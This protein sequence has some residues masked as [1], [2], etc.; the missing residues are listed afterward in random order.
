MDATH[1]GLSVCGSVRQNGPLYFKQ[2]GKCSIAPPLYSQLKGQRSGSKSQ[3][4]RK[5]RDYF[6]VVTLLQI[7]YLLVHS[8]QIPAAGMLAVC[9]ALQIFCCFFYRAMLCISAV[10]AVMRCLSVRLSVRLSVTFVDHVKTNK[11]IF[12]IFS[13]AGS[14]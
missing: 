13:P 5:C 9:L 14:H 7:M 3:K 8:V 10:Y 6:L 11:H 12:E 2:R 1:V 4:S